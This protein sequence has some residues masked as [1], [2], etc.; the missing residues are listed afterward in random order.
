MI[1]NNILMI[2]HQNG[3]MKM[4]EE[5]LKKLV[6]L[7]KELQR[8]G[9]PCMTDEPLADCKNDECGRCCGI[10]NACEKTNN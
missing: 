5:E 8:Q 4:T 2:Q 9:Q 1:K 6:E 3:E 7:D 10:D